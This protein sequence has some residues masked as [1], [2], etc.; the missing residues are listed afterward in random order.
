MSDFPLVYVVT[1]THNHCDDTLRAL[2]SLSRM[3]YP[4][5]KLLVVDNQSTDETV[6]RV[7]AEYPEVELLVHSSNLGFAA[8]INPGLEY[9]LDHG[10]DFVLVINND[11]LVAPSLLT[12][13]VTAMESSIGAVA[14]MIH[15][16]D[17]PKHI[18]SI[19]FSK[20]SLLLEMRG[21][22]RGHVDEGQWREPFEVDY[23]LGCA[24]L[25]NSSALRKVGLFDE[26]YYFYYEDLD[27]SLRVRQHG[28][29]LITVPQANMWHKVAGS[30]GMG[31]AF[32]VYHM[33]RSSVI[34]LRTHTCGLQRP[35]SFL[36]RSGSALKKSLKFLMCGQLQLLREYWRG[37]Q[38]GWRIS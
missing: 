35:A 15:Y 19:G 23:L 26:R 1:L 28:Y 8:G 14:P 36:F 17:A 33:A 25:L 10:A 9:A 24:I 11:V 12:H 6:E 18:W 2:D 20:H 30:A 27:F 5:Y 32:R 4:S 38:D 3:T 7:R 13:L 22:A 34:F 37:L 31:S 29:R 16:L 21:G